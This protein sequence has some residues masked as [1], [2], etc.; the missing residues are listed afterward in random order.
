MLTTFFSLLHSN[1]AKTTNMPSPIYSDTQYGKCNNIP[2]VKKEKNQTQVV[3]QYL[4][5]FEKLAKKEYA[6][7][8]FLLQTVIT[9]QLKNDYQN[10]IITQND[11]MEILDKTDDL[12]NDKKYA[13]RSSIVKS[14]D[15]SLTLLMLQVDR[16]KIDFSQQL[17]QEQPWLQQVIHKNKQEH[18]LIALIKSCLYDFY[19]RDFYLPPINFSITFISKNEPLGNN[20]NIEGAAC[21][22]PARNTLYLYSGKYNKTILKHELWHWLITQ[23]S[24]ALKS[25]NQECPQA[26]LDSYLYL[27]DFSNELEDAYTADYSCIAAINKFQ[28]EPSQLFNSIL[29]VKDE[30]QALQ[31]ITIVRQE[32]QYLIDIAEQLQ[33][34]NISNLFDNARKCFSP[35]IIEFQ[36]AVN[37]WLPSEFSQSLSLKTFNDYLERGLIYKAPKSSAK[38]ISRVYGYSFYIHT[39]ELETQQG[40]ELITLKGHFIAN[41]NKLNAKLRGFINELKHIQYLLERLYPNEIIR[42]AAEYDASIGQLPIRMQ[43]LLHRW[44]A[45]HHQRGTIMFDS[46][47]GVNRKP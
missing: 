43:T 25:L 18:Q 33:Q 26:L 39:T 42:K 47:N 34:R 6:N 40:F 19:R 7:D 41:Q 45:F 21:Y 4:K 17:L 46:K 23:T 31:L 10:N 12:I 24:D 27:K 1:L 35:A 44:K 5:Q 15:N 3:M 37:I 9:E 13:A 20:E 16:V 8:L 2:V 11:Y 28:S 38:Y 29:P 14:K 36:Q 22:R 32:M 30:Q